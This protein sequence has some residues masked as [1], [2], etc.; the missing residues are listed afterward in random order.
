MV[1]FVSQGDEEEVVVM[2]LYCV[3][4]CL[5]YHH[6]HHGKLVRLESLYAVYDIS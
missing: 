6:H 4:V 2:Y 1:K 5:L 3:C